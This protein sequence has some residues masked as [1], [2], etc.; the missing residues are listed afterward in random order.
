MEEWKEGGIEGGR[1]GRLGGR[2]VRGLEGLKEGGLVDWRA[3]GWEVGQG[4]RG[5]AGGRVGHLLTYLW[6]HFTALAR[7]SHVCVLYLFYLF[8]FTSRR[9]M[10][11]I[12]DRRRAAVVKQYLYPGVTFRAPRWGGE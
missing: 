5:R 4:S 2:W 9:T 10:H 12:R 11:N 7:L 3:E 8:F 6:P 1:A